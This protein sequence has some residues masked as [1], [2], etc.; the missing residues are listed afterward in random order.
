LQDIR[1]NGT[2]EAEGEGQRGKFGEE[3][4]VVCGAKPQKVSSECNLIGGAYKLR[5]TTSF[6]HCNKDV[7]KARCMYTL[8]CFILQ[9]TVDYFGSV[10]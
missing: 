7:S 4:I 2:V 10:L 8:T 5:N 1:R 6:S 9:R 3:E